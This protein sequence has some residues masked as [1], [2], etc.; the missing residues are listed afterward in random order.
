MDSFELKERLRLYV[1]TDER[2][3]H[4]TLLETIEAAIE[5]GATA[6]QLRR[7]GDLGKRFVQLGRAL[8]TLTRERDVLFFV[9]DRVDVAMLVDADGVHIGQDDISCADARRLMG[10][11]I[12]GVSAS[13]IEQAMIAEQDGADYLGVGS[14]Y[15]T[16]SKPDADFTGMNGL[17]AITQATTLPVVAIGGIHKEN[18]TEVMRAGADGIAVVSAIMSA[19]NPKTAAQILLGMMNGKR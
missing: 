12:I 2:P 11:K 15:S 6:V 10:N 19:P 17:S 18:L 4:Q 14:V 5:G 13:S 16:S 7:K 9:N 1:V 8:R 3:D